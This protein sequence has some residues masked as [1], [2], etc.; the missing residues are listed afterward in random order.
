MVDNSVESRGSSVLTRTNNP[1]EGTSQLSNLTIYFCGFPHIV[2]FVLVRCRDKIFHGCKG[3][4]I[5]KGKLLRNFCRR[6]TVMVFAPL[7]L[8]HCKYERKKHHNNVL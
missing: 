1:T 8:I 4:I 5:G 6:S 2:L 3:A 7:V